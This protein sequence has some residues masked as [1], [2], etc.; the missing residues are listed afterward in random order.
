MY[1]LI[2]IQTLAEIANILFVEGTHWL[3]TKAASRFCGRCATLLDRLVSFV[4]SRLDCV[5]NSVFP[6]LVGAH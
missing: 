6:V 4:N 2:F 3:I 5:L 1:K